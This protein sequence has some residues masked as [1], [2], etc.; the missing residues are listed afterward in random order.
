MQQKKIRQL[1]YWETFNALVHDELHGHGNI[2]AQA[3]IDGVITEQALHEALENIYAQQAILQCLLIQENESY[4]LCEKT[5]FNNIPIVYTD[6]G[7]TQEIFTR[8]LKTPLETRQ[9][10]W[11]VNCVIDQQQDTTNLIITLSHA[12]G[13]G[14]SVIKLLIAI[15]DSLNAKQ[16][17]QTYQLDYSPL[18]P[19]I[20]LQLDPNKFKRQSQKILP[21]KETL[22]R[23]QWTFHE[24]SA[25]IQQRNTDTLLQ[26]FST[27]FIASLKQNC[28]QHN[29]TIQ[30]ALNAALLKAMAEIEQKDLN[31]QLC[32]PINLRN[33]TKEE[34]SNDSFGCFVTMVTTEHSVSRSNSTMLDLATDYHEKL[35]NSI[36]NAGQY[37]SEFTFSDIMPYVEQCQADR[38]TFFMDVGVTNVGKL[39]TTVAGPYKLNDI[40]FCASRQAADFMLLICVVTIN[41]KLCLTYSY[42]EPEMDVEWITNLAEGF[43]RELM[44]FAE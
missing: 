4:W 33:F 20:E 6:K 39:S 7:S 27:E 17:K 42:A 19:P 24:K 36:V 3:S 22:P 23:E 16:T 21:S 26:T 28:K 13:D 35:H 15:I 2:V 43:E 25:D 41:D 5:A 37:P 18:L 12:I 14:L 32:T 40:R 34:A 29:V 30:D 44:M 31:I 8:E 10:L 11:R 1:G 38:N 9:Y